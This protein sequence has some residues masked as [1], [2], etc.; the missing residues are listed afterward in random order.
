MDRFFIKYSKYDIFVVINQKLC[1]V[2]GQKLVWVVN[3]IGSTNTSTFVKIR[4][5]TQN[6]HGM[7]RKPNP[8]HWYTFIVSLRTWN[9]K[10]GPVCKPPSNCSRWGCTK[11]SVIE[12]KNLVD[13]LKL[14]SGWYCLI[15][16]SP[17]S[18]T[19]AKPAPNVPA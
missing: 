6:W 11:K 8:P 12:K 17:M 2:C 9:L 7:T 3:T 15:D 5:V 10:V 16:E 18:L 4:E 1:N 13:C 14:Y 19:M